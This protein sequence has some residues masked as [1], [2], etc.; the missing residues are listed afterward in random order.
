MERSVATEALY[1]GKNAE[2]CNDKYHLSICTLC[3]LWIKI[4]NKCPVKD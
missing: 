3:K 1:R 2:S 4:S